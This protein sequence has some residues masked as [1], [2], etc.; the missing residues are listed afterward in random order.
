MVRKVASGSMLPRAK[1]QMHYKEEPR[2]FVDGL[3][4]ECERYRGTKH[5]SKVLGKVVLI[6]NGNAMDDISLLEKIRNY[7]VPNDWE[8]VQV[9][10]SSEQVNI[11][12][13]G[14]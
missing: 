14:T 9:C 12:E 11:E 13:A 3:D 8:L 10:M 6:W 7:L 1:F 2:R 5:N 4:A